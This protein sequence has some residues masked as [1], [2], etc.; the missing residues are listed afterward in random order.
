MLCFPHSLAAAKEEKAD[1][2]IN[3]INISRGTHIIF[4]ICLTHNFL[5]CPS[6]AL[7]LK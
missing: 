6:V 4:N 5:K 2:I 1:H 7:F 3:I